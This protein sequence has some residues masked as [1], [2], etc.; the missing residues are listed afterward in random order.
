MSPCAAPRAPGAGDRSAWRTATFAA[1]ASSVVRRRG[2]PG[3]RHFGHS[4]DRESAPSGLPQLVHFPESMT[5]AS[6]HRLPV[7]INALE[8]ECLRGAG[9][10]PADGLEEMPAQTNGRPRHNPIPRIWYG[11]I[12]KPCAKSSILFSRIV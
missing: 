2:T 9:A 3:V 5:H 11:R 12:V 6:G 1:A 8:F 7:R 10:S 4:P